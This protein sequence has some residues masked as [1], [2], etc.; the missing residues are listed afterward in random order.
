MEK[1]RLPI[2]TDNFSKLRQN[3]LY[4]VDKTGLIRELLESWSEVTLFTRPRRFGK[5]LNTSMLKAFFE[6]GTEKALFDGLVISQEKE[7]CD[8]YMGRF[9]VISVSLK[10][11][12]AADYDSAR[13]RLWN[14][15][16]EEAER[17]SFLVQSG[18]LDAL[19][20]ENFMRLRKGEGSLE[21]SLLMLS[22]ILC[23]HYDQKVIIL[24]DEYD[25]PL[26]KSARYGYYDRMIILIR[27][28]FSAV[29]K[30]NDYL[31]FAV[32]TGC[33]RISKE[34]LFS[35]LNNL[36]VYSIVDNRFDEWFGF[37]DAEVRKMLEDFELTDYYEQTKEWY[38]G[39]RIGQ[40][41]VYCPW[42]VINWCD[43]LINDTNH[44]PENFWA[45]TSGDDRILQFVDMADD[46]TKRELER[47]SAGESVE[48]DLTL[49]LTYNELGNSMNHFW[50]VLF[51]AGYLTQCGK[52]EYGEY[53]LVIPNR[54]I[55]HVFDQQIKRC[56]YRKI[57]SNLTA[58]YKALSEG[59][60]RTVEEQLNISMR[61]SISFMDG[62]NSDEQRESFYHG[63][64]LGMLKDRSGWKIRSNR[65][66]GSGRADIIVIDQVNSSG[67]IIEVKYAKDAKNENDV[68]AL[69]KWADIALK[70]VE[71]NQYDQYF[72]DGEIHHIFK[73]GVAFY[74]KKCR[75][76]KQL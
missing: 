67:Y 3:H 76:K 30:S 54:E 42:D 10:T 20:K 7:L 18:R 21:E 9:P 40:Q 60:A 32:L 22:R 36:K 13:L 59:N 27:T 11:V 69:E 68:A 43:K 48:K 39:Y 56:F 29:L 53:R 38:D 65:E 16:R 64:L 73:Y 26:D 44:D 61:E 50:S 4:Y 63:L 24:I 28:M 2:G 72:A 35:D 31:Q 62:G 66:A 25:V 15:V 6:I 52:N 5:T 47:L 55:N 17:F 14:V 70:Q 75:V 71:N 49:N 12:E 57:G 41:D 33:M 37:T 34:S 8:Q 51:T 46:A 1:R 58:L 45:N 74:K 23:K 19:D